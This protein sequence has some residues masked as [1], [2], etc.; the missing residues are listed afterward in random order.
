MS[1]TRLITT[2]VDE[3]L[4]ERVKAAADRDRRPVSSFVR[5][6]LADAVADQNTKPEHGAAA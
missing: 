2:R 3:E 4:E 6:V 5:N 1:K